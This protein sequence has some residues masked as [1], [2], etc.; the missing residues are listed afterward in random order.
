MGSCVSRYTN[1]QQESHNSGKAT[2]ISSENDASKSDALVRSSELLRIA[3]PSDGSFAAFYPE[4]KFSSQ[5]LPNNA[6][7]GAPRISPLV[8]Q[9]ETPDPTPTKPYQDDVTRPEPFRQTS[10][11]ESEKSSESNP[12]SVESASTPPSTVPIPM[13]AREA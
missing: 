10:L 5:K 13:Y 7:L 12:V 1:V 9:E 2:A 4:L 11:T 6:S 8:V 3:E